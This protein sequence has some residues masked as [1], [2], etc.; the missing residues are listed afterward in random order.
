MGREE[1]Y[2]FVEGEN[3]VIF[4][5]KNGVTVPHYTRGLKINDFENFFARYGM[6]KEKEFE[7]W[8]IF[9]NNEI[10]FEILS[11]YEPSYYDIPKPKMKLAEYLAVVNS[12]HFRLKKPAISN[13]T[14]D[15]LSAFMKEFHLNIH[16]VDDNKHYK[17]VKQFLMRF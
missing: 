6:K 9:E 4:E 5:G 7:D 14:K 16:S 11:K 17:N 8:F 15:L 12:S 3:K 13:E 1:Y 2:Y 10:A